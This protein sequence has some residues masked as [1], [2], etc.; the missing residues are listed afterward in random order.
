MTTHRHA[1]EPFIESTLAFFSKR[2]TFFDA[3]WYA[4]RVEKCACGQWRF[5]P[6]AP[7]LQTVDVELVDPETAQ[8]IQLKG[9]YAA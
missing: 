6:E 8:S 1:Y 9:D 5:V 2:G 7:G 4:G 3:S